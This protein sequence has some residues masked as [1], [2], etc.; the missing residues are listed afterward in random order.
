MAALFALLKKELKTYLS[1][2]QINTIYKAYLFA[3]KA[4]TK[5]SRSSGVLYITHPMAVATILAKMRMDPASIM[6]AILHDVIEDTELDK[7]T[8]IEKFGEEIVKLV[9]GVTKLTH[10]KFETQAKAQAENFRKMILAM[11]HDIRVI[12]IRLADRLHNMRTL[13]YLTPERRHRIAKETLEIYAP[14]A[15]RLG[16]YTF[17]TELEELAFERLHPYRHKILYKAIKQARGHR[18]EIIAMFSEALKESLQKAK[19]HVIKISGREKELY[20]VYRKM[21]QKNVKFSEIMDVYGFRIVVEKVEDCYHTLGIVHNLYKPVPGKFKD[22]IA[23]PKNNGY[24]S[25][26]TI[27]FGPYGLPIE[28]Q[29]RTDDMDKMAE[30]GIAAHWLYKSDI[31]I[32]DKAQ[33]RAQAWIKDLLELQKVAGDSLDFIE[34]VRLDLF[35]DAVYVFAPKGDIFELPRGATVIDFAYNVHSDIGN[36]CIAAKIN[37]VLVPLSTRLHNGQTIE[38]ITSE[39]THPNPDWLDFAITAKARSRIHHYLK[40]QKR[41]EAIALGHQLL[42]RSLH[43]QHM[44]A[45][46]IPMQNIKNTLKNLKLRTLDDLYEAI[47]L[48]NQ[49]AHLVAKRFQ[50]GEQPHILETA[51]TTQKT[52]EPLQIKGSEGLMLNFAKCCYPVPGD[53]IQGLLTTGHGIV[54][55]HANCKNLI[56][57]RKKPDRCIPLHWEE[58]IKG[59]FEVALE[60]EAIQQHDI[61]ASIALALTDVNTTI[62]NIHMTEQ[63]SQCCRIDVII[64]VNDREHL[65]QILRTLQR[66]KHVTKV[67]RVQNTE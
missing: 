8:L 43:S 37:R 14:I 39:E 45:K 40:N 55:H 52:T 32:A 50:D 5:Q 62:N 22:Y 19:I 17:K 28:I 4:H 57:F 63:E 60:I 2:E 10:I 13:Q 25:L 56:E 49:M 26:H 30:Y 31:N 20:S 38:I 42:S 44:V 51:T 9:D 47:G 65:N 35:P 34:N 61:L 33:V 64:V 1:Q 67:T 59:K 66:L 24:Q 58:N 11:T 46:D 36:R 12:L 27:L 15:A 23:I 21:E 41:S 7:N 16:M 6:A 54:V 18:K 29:I 3:A 48:G 53:P